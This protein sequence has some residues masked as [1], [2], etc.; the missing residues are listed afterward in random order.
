MESTDKWAPQDVCL[1]LIRNETGSSSNVKSSLTFCSSTTLGVEFTSIL[2]GRQV[3]GE[4]KTLFGNA[5]PVLSD[6]FSW[7]PLTLKPSCVCDTSNAQPYQALLPAANDT[8]H[9]AE[10]LASVAEQGLLLCVHIVWS[11]NQTV[12]LIQLPVCSMVQGA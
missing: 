4:G 5:L 9:N 3:V 8:E 11:V 6:H 12:Q 7:F 10:G 1:H 2:S